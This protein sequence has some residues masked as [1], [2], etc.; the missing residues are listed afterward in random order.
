MAPVHNIGG[1]L[2][3][4]AIVLAL[5]ACTEKPEPPIR[6]STCELRDQ[7]VE[8]D[9]K[10]VEVRAVMVTDMMHYLGLQSA[11]CSQK[12]IEMFFD[13]NAINR[14]C[15]DSEFAKTVECPIDAHSWRIEATFVGEFRAEDAKLR[16]TAMTDILR[17]PNPPWTPG[18]T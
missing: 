17:T 13:D 8:Y 5:I 2:L 9:R 14:P 4:F 16:V 11:G 1:M 3:V 7:R 10:I 6:V 18:A 12:P 15:G